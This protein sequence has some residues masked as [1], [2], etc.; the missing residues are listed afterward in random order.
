MSKLQLHASG[1]EALSKCGIAYERRYILGEKSEPS[2]SMLV[3]TAVDRSVRLNMTAKK[4][5]GVLLFVDD[6]KDAARD[7]LVNEWQSGVRLS[8]EDK[9]DGTSSQAHAIDMSVNLA[10]LHHGKLAPAINPTHV[11]RQWVL[12]VKGHDIQIAGEIDIQEGIEAIRDTKTS[13][14]SPVKTLADESLQLSTYALAVRQL[15]GVL[16]KKVVLDY[17]VQTPARGDLKLV[18]LESRRDDEHLEPVL[19]RIG[20]MEQVLR[21]GLFTP[22]PISSWWCAKKYCA[23]WK[24]AG[25]QRAR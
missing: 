4:E 21:S 23:Y 14:K 9:E 22:A 25:M 15:E 12:E 13:R 8:E 11:A 20:Q 18:Q 1:M 2:A 16:P 3:G 10:G 7:A 6:V 24:R 17:L 5:T 19:A